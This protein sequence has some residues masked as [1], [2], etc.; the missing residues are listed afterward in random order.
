MHIRSDL[1]GND[2]TS[3]CSQFVRSVAAASQIHR[4][5]LTFPCTV[6]LRGNACSG[7]EAASG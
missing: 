3:L 2:N 4:R 1:D 7:I 6:D 5:S